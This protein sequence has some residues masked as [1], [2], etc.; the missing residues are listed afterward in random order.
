M[1]INTIH[2][3]RPLPLVLHVGYRDY[4]TCT[5]F[6]L[7]FTCLLCFCS[8]NVVSVSFKS[9]IWLISSTIYNDNEIKEAL[10]FAFR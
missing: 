6:F 5:I 9:M 8:E 1:V 3:C 2:Y 4:C 10:V 7:F